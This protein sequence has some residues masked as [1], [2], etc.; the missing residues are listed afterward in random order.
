MILTA[1][2]GPFKDFSLEEMRTVTP[3]QALNHPNWD[4]GPKI[5]IDSATMMNK[6]L[7]ATE[8]K[9]LFDLSMDQITILIHT[10]SVI[11]SMVEYQDGAVIHR[12]GD[13]GRALSVVR[14]GAVRM[15]NM[16]RDG[17]EVTL[18]TLS[19]GESFGEFTVFADLPR[20]F[21]FTAR[22]KTVIDTINHQRFEALLQSSPALSQ[23]VIRHLA[24]RLHPIIVHYHH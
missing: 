24:Q 8:A 21:D 5:S 15:S 6:G 23:H 1:S 20:Q 2:G 7:E 14:T 19:P 16:G 13:R 3:Q 18:T 22:G 11:H 9:W 12:R 4:M 10:Q 17:R